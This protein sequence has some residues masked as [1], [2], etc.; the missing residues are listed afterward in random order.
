MTD[1]YMLKH[2]IDRIEGWRRIYEVATELNIE[3]PLEDWNEEDDI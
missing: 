1:L 3:Q 2:G